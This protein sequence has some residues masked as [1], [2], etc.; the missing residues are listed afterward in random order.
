MTISRQNQRAIILVI[1]YVF[2]ERADVLG[3]SLPTPQFGKRAMLL[4]GED[5]CR[6]LFHTKDDMLVPRRGYDPDL[7]VPAVAVR[8]GRG[9][10]RGGRGARGRGAGRGIQAK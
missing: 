6:V 5:M 2:A 3:V 8:G 4:T 1:I 10:G 9:R 7:P